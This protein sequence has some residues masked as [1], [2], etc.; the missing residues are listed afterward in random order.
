MSIFQ[1]NKLKTELNPH[2]TQNKQLNIELCGKE[3]KGEVVWEIE[4]VILRV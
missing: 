2:I 4:S 3:K 1:L